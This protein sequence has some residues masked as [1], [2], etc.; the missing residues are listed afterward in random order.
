VVSVDG[1]ET[2]A[3]DNK[4]ANVL[5][6][7][8]ATFWHTPWSGGVA[9]PPP[10]TIVIDLGH[11]Y[12]VSA[13]TYLP[14]QDGSDH[15]TIATYVLAVSVDGTTWSIPVATG[16]WSA[17]RGLKTVEWPAQSGRFVWL[18]ALAE[19][20]GRAWS[21]VAELRVFGTVAAEPVPAAPRSSD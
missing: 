2:M 8:P 10:H 9:P 16:R 20:R 3:A 1:E 14:R 7:N 18:A 11:V 17:N 12:Q 21:S 4:S 19:S 15:G 5:D 6:N 13:L